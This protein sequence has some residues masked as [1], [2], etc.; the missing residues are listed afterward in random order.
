MIYDDLVPKEEA[1]EMIKRLHIP[2]YEEARHYFD[3]AIAEGV[4]EPNTAPGFP[5]QSQINAVLTY[6]RERDSRR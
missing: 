6:V 3:E 2:G 4:Y 5:H 1:L